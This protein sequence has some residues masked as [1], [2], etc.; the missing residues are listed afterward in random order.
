[1]DDIGLLSKRSSIFEWSKMS[2][3]AEYSYAEWLNM[4]EQVIDKVCW[5]LFE[6][7][8]WSTFRFVGCAGW[9]LEKWIC[10][11]KVHA[12]NPLLTTSF[13]SALVRAMFATTRYFDPLK[14]KERGYHVTTCG[15]GRVRDCILHL[16]GSARRF[17]VYA[18]LIYT[19]SSWLLRTS[20]WVIVAEGV[21]V[22]SI[23]FCDFHGV[24]KARI[25]GKKAADVVCGVANN[26]IGKTF[27]QFSLLKHYDESK[28]RKFTS[29]FFQRRGDTAFCIA[30]LT[31]DGAYLNELFCIMLKN[32]VWRPSPSRLLSW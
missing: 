13:W 10:S 23:R 15:A 27:Y 12:P 24:I 7:L 30:G 19:Q 28:P 14:V 17:V 11:E 20:R 5:V 25:S 29:F 4:F 21:L 26:L 18:S 16:V 2:Q 22:C 1:M 6:A 3:D 31:A 32:C 8:F 9:T